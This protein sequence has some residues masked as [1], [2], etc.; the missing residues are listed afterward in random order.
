MTFRKKT[1]YSKLK[2]IAVIPAPN[3]NAAIIAITATTLTSLLR[4]AS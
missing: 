2:I 3:R 1:Y 4:S